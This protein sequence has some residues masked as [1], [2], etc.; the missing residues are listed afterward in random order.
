[1]PLAQAARPRRSTRQRAHLT[2]LMSDHFD[3][4][5]IPVRRRQTSGSRSSL[6]MDVDPL[7]SPSPQH[8]ELDPIPS[9]PQALD[10]HLSDPSSSGTCDMALALSVLTQID[11]PPICVNWTNAYPY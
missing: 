7:P 1:M 4:N 11:L 3:Y 10:A 8:M 5:N 9:A 6:N 2:L